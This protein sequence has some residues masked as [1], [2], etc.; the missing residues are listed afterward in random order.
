MKQSNKKY[1]ARILFSLSD[2][3]ALAVALSMLPLL[4]GEVKYYLGGKLVESGHYSCYSILLLV[5]PS[6]QCCASTIMPWQKDSNRTTTHKD[7][8][9]FQK[10]HQTF[11]I[12]LSS[13]TILLYLFLLQFSPLIKVIS[14]DFRCLLFKNC[15]VTTRD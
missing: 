1:I 6:L 10:Q 7:S 12:Y 14:D 3:M 4:W 13:N 8:R 9:F 2:K 5:M 15:T 11:S